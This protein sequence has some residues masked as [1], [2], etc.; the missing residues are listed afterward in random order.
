LP[1]IDNEGKYAGTITEGDI[2]WFLKHSPNLNFRDTNKVMVEDIPKHQNNKTVSINSDI[3]DL[4]L[5]SI[6]QNFIPVA[7]DHDIF[8]GIIKR[9]DIINYFYKLLLNKKI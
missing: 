2:L 4:I 1:L 7:D 3:E 8:I 6:N 9:S 5:L